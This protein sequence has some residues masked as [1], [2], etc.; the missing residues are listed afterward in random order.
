MDP[1][2]YEGRTR[3]KAV[4]FGFIYGMHENKFIEQ[5]E[6]DYGWTPSKTEAKSSREAYFQLYSMLEPWHTKTKRL[7]RL[8]GHVRVLTGR[9]RRLPGIQARDRQVK[10]EAERQAVNSPVQGL[11]GD[12]KAMC[13]VEI[14]QTFPRSQCRLVGEHHDAVLCIVK[15]EHVDEVVPK[16]LQIAEHPALLDTF[17]IN[18]SVPMEGEAELGNWGKGKKYERHDTTGVQRRKRRTRKHVASGGH[19]G[20]VAS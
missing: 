18:L 17:K 15:D 10:S 12:Y 20:V 16:M 13:L 3:A 6:K 2:W 8:N 5:A 11:I 1:D 14:H 7:A 4:N 19:R 9:L